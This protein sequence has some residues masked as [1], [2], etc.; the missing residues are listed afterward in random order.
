MKVVI[1]CAG[2][3]HGPPR[4]FTHEGKHVEFVASPSLTPSDPTGRVAYF[5]P[6]DPAP[7]AGK[8]WR[9]VLEEYN[10]R[11]TNEL[12]FRAAVD[13]YLPPIY[14]R[15]KNFATQ[16]G[17]ELFI[18]SAGWG[19]VRSNYWLPNYNITFAQ[20]KKVPKY[21]IRSLTEPFQ[22]FQHMRVKGLDEPI[23]YFGSCRF[24]P[25]APYLRIF[26]ELAAR[27]GGRKIAYYLASTKGHPP[28]WNGF[29]FCPYTP[30]DPAQRQNWHYGC[31]R[32]FIE[33]RLRW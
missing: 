19:L 20:A 23:Y 11:G 27:T 14:Q 26:R 18:L 8:T 7:D 6:D 1:T 21:A 28:Q 2:E 10:T 25:L 29:E 15:L 9:T 5:R 31:A 24:Q 30:R 4:S 22:D 33:N 13:L 12:G 32:D 17:A 3:K 16:N